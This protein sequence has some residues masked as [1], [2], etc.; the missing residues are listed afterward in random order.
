M[1]TII[2]A[3][4]S[5]RRQEILSSLG[6]PFKT[7]EPNIDET[8]W[9]HLPI[10]KRVIAIAKAK[11]TQIG[12]QSKES[13]DHWYL[14]ADTLIWLSRKRKRRGVA[15]G[16]PNDREEA[17]RMIK[18]LAGRTH[19]VWTGIAVFN[20]SKKEYYTGFSKSRVRF[21]T[22]S[23]KETSEY[24]DTDDWVGVAGAYKI[25][26]QAGKFIESIKGSWSGI[27]GLPVRELY[28]ILKRAALL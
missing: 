16:K 10:Q 12:G 9:D 17:E 15:L 24:L 23:S 26:G 6:I 19:S 28:V 1:N 14:A 18:S 13:S 22:M 11:A 21:A 25:Q 5:P 20:C 8:Q 3:S 2:L 4:S 27:V 7:I